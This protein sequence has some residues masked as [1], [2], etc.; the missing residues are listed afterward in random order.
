MCFLFKGLDHYWAILAWPWLLGLIDWV[1]EF[2]GKGGL[3]GVLRLLCRNIMLGNIVRIIVFFWYDRRRIMWIVICWRRYKWALWGL[4]RMIVWDYLSGIFLAMLGA[5]V[6]SI[7]EKGSK[8]IILMYAALTCLG[9]WNL[10]SF[11]HYCCSV[12]HNW[13]K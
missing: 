10:F 3:I 13:S 8:I 4:V 2:F 1:R 7:I 12:L 6:L 9:I 5:R 11:T